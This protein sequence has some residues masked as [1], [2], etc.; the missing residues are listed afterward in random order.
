MG[1][2]DLILAAA[3]GAVCLA[4]A[5]TF[6]AY[7]QGRR[8]SARLTHL[9]DR[10]KSAEFEAEAARGAV[11]AFDGAVVAICGD[12]ATLVS[13][14]EILDA[15]ARL[16]ASRSTPRAVLETLGLADPQLGARL[17]ALVDAGEPFTGQVHRGD[18]AVEVE[19]RAGGAMCWV[20]LS[21]RQDAE[22]QDAD[23]GLPSAGLLTDFLDAQAE[24]IW[25]ARASGELAWANQAWLRAVEAPTLDSARKRKLS[26]DKGAE[27]LGK[28]AIA[29]GQAQ[30]AQ[31]WITLDGR[32]RAFLI[33]AKPLP[34]SLAALAA[35]D[36]TDAEEAKDQLRRHIEA[37]GETFDHIGE[38][39]A[40]FS[41][42]K[43]LMFHN[44]AFAELWGLEPAW[45]SD[46]PTHGEILDRLRQ[47]RRLPETVDYAGWKAAELKRYEA[48]GGHRRR[49]LALPDGRTL[50]IVR[51]IH[52]TGGLL[53]LFSD[54][55][56]ELKLKAQYNGLIQVQQATL[57]KLSD[58]VAVFG[59]DGRL[60]LHN[61]A[62]SDLW[63]VTG[64][65]LL[66]AGDFDGVV[67]HCVRKV[68]DLAL[69]SDLKARVTD[70]DPQARA[71]LT[72]EVR[73][74]DLHI[75]AYQ[76]RPLPDGATLIA[77][78]DITDTRELEGALVDR[79]AALE[80][81]E[82]LKRDFVGNVSYELRTPLT[83]IIGY[84]ELLD[85]MGA[86]LSERA[87]G[88]VQ[89]VRTAAGHLARS[90]DDVLD[91][92]QVDAGEMQ[93]NLG[94]A[95]VQPLLAG[96]AERWAREA[97][98]AEARIVIDCPEDIGV[99][100]ADARRLGQVLD[101]LTENA[102]R[103]S[104]K[105]GVVHLAARRGLGEIQIEVSD[106]GRGIPFHVQAHIFD[107]FTTRD[108]GGPGLGLALVKALVELH[109]GW[110]ALQ[111]EPGQGAAFTCHLP[112]EAY[113]GG[114]GAGAAVLAAVGHLHVHEAARPHDAARRFGGDGA[115]DVVG[116]RGRLRVARPPSP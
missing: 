100:R 71:A 63:N 74:S 28:D 97:Q 52:P 65:Q 75:F 105:G 61:E 32:R 111:S 26:F 64:A 73:T 83:T 67:E 107:R 3:F 8:L 113:A 116:R 19:G 78:A 44:T 2:S 72:G 39:V 95:P 90:I 99:V 98:E 31:R 89:A 24:P 5:A 49:D 57:D 102:V 27:A 66:T 56:D 21:L 7:A 9:S 18:A 109:G 69:W 55:T 87:R 79:S 68:H 62:F 76:S 60:R 23:S 10:L 16:F 25:L 114:C 82:R 45:L 50:R 112:E 30:T 53:L 1:A 22:G 48:L 15:C 6:W 34:G 54:I 94:D 17:Q 29:A 12:E 104:P 51:Q 81:T 101:H 108:R 115:A 11:D 47:R 4:L 35:L 59:S 14:D 58:A 84:S 36:V 86:A 103:Q 92:A 106:Q 38:A 80:E 96:A 20:R 40:I 77:F 110:I 91:M 88:H 43:T 41:P 70:T 46:Q 13:G 37:Q 93:L 42:Q 85:H 33:T